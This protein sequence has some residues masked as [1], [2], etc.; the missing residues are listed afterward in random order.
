MRKVQV[1]R[2]E[3]GEVRN[4]LDNISPVYQLISFCY[5]LIG[6]VQVSFTHRKDIPNLEQRRMA[7]S[8]GAMDTT[9]SRDVWTSIEPLS[10]RVIVDNLD[11]HYKRLKRDCYTDTLISKVK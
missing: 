9:T 7:T 3:W 1:G 2:D 11:L 8:R 4:D 5:C 6:S 10:R